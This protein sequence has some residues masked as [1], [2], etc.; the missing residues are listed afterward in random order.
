MYYFL[1]HFAFE[2]HKISISDAEVTS[3]LK[4][5]VALIQNLNNNNLELILNSMFSNISV[6]G[7]ALKQHILL[8]DQKSKIF[9]LDVLK[10]SSKPFCSDLYDEYQ[11]DVVIM[12]DCKEAVD[13]IDVLETFLACAMYLKAPII[14]PDKL[15]SKSQFLESPINIQCNTGHNEKLDNFL[16]S[17]QHLLI[18]SLKTQTIQNISD[19][20]TYINHVN[21]NLK[22]IEILEEC[23]NDLKVYSFNSI[24]GRNIREDM[25][26]I[27]TFIIDNGGNPAHVQYK[28]LSKHINE[29]TQNKLVKRKSKLTRKD[30]DGKSKTMSWHTRIGDY[31]LYF[32][33][34]NDIV[35]FTLFCAKIPE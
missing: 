34:T 7:K 13:G 4:E 21:S 9:M 17:N 10:R 14:T 29:E 5:M 28:E 35:Y 8:L 31:R 26:K 15:C 19:W 20:D 27:N 24:Q 22:K 32:Y 11:E 16:L 25:E 2:H 1:N 12:S 3:T 33:F 18:S 23:A 30:K 6:N